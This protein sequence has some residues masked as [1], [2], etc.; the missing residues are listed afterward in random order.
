MSTYTEALLERIR[1]LQDEIEAEIHRGRERFRYRLENGRVVFEAEMRQRH[2]AFRVKLSTFLRQARPMVIITA[3]V[4][5]AMNHTDNFNYWPFQYSLHC[6]F[7]R[8][9]ATWVKGKN[10]EGTISS[11]F[12]RWT[13][14]SVMS[15]SSRDQMS[16]LTWMS[17]LSCSGLARSKAGGCS[18]N[19][20]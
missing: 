12:M 13:T 5:Y 1:Q 3:P 4:I 20:T 7:Q 19:R 18:L 11:A 10:Y 15:R 14:W 8:Y 6:A 9:T 17:V 16:F 2:R